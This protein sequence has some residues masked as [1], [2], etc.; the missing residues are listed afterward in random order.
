VASFERIVRVLTGAAML[1]AAK[2][3]GLDNRSSRG[4]VRSVDRYRS[5][6]R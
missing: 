1:A 3:S 4:I 2:D 5:V 6:D